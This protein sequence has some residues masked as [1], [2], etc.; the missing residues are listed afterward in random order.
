MTESTKRSISPLIL[1]VAGYVLAVLFAWAS[2]VSQ[3]SS[4]FAVAG[5][6]AALVLCGLGVFI[7][8]RRLAVGRS[9]RILEILVLV[10]GMV[11][12]AWAMLALHW[13]IWK[14]Y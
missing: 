7:A 4:E 2:S 14:P 9:R 1:V 5:M 10:L 11:G 13:A 6:V 3:H 8:G 12:V